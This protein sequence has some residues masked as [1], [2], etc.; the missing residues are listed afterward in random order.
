V[1]PTHIQII[2]NRVVWASSINVESEKNRLA[3][4]REDITKIT[5]VT[6]Y[7]YKKS[8]RE[9]LEQEA[10]LSAKEEANN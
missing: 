10:L 1:F 3:K 8:K 4:I 2:S 5:D 6:S 7:D 9:I